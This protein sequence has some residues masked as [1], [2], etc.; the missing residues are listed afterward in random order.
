MAYKHG[1]VV[2]IPDPHAQHP[3][4]PAV[5]VSDG[6]CPDH[7]DI[8]TVAPLTTSPEYGAT[9]YAMKVEQYEPVQGELLEDSY[10]EPWATQT[11]AH[12]DISKAVA[13][14]GPSTMKRVAKGYAM[15]V[16]QG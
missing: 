11:I 7:G 6:D 14:L 5:V 8:Y 13:R 2:L 16:L 15:L 1:H 4:R 12:E 10:V 9:R 3:S